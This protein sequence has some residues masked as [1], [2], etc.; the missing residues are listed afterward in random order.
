MTDVTEYFDDCRECIRGLWNGHFRERNGYS[1]TDIDFDA[2]DELRQIL[3]QALVVSRAGSSG[4]RL[5]QSHGD[6]FVIPIAKDGVPVLVRRPSDDG[7]AY[8]DAFDGRVSEDQVVLTFLDF[9]DWESIRFTDLRYYLV[10]IQDWPS[11]PAYI[12]R[13]ALLDTAHTRV[14]LKR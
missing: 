14:V 2:F 6:F 11:M 9:F 5:G 4:A 10:E 13:Q 7:N 12:G 1:P 3:F 8:W